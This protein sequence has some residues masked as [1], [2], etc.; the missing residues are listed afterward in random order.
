MQVELPSHH[1]PC[2][3]AVQKEETASSCLSLKEE[4]GQFQLED[5]REE[6]GEPVIEVSDLEDKFDKSLGVC[7]AGFILA[8][9][10]SS[11]EEEEEEEKEEEEEE[12][13]LERKKGSGLRE[14]L[15]GRSKGSASKDASGFQLSLP[16]PPPFP[17]VSPYALANLKKRKK[18]KEVVEEGELVPTNE[19]VPLKMPKTAKGKGRASLA[20]SKEVEHVAEVHPPNSMWNPWLKLDGA[21]IPWNSTIREF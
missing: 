4:I 1:S 16:L 5:E 10:T 15:V 8:H 12:M 17:S 20:E 7:S 18:D 6:Q 13:P 19:G 2:E 11:L 14:L 9:I 21:I 3:E